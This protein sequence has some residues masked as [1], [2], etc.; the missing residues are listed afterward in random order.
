MFARLIPII[1]IGLP[2]AEIAGFIAAGRTFGLLPTLLAV[3]VTGI[4]GALVLR[5]QGLAALG[6]LQRR[7]AQGEMP[8]RAVGNAML[9]GLGGLL[10]LIPGFITD[11]FGL[12]LLLPITRAAIFGWLSKRL[13]VVEVDA[14]AYRPA[15]RRQIDLDDDEWRNG[16]SL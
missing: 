14:S 5:W 6:E 3:V 11:L 4:A 16:P 9:I 8:A 7:V 2:L 13:K 10:L 1:I 12:A 15:A